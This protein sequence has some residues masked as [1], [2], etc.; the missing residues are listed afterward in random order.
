MSDR[1]ALS[2][3]MIVKNE[4]KF[5]PSCLHSVRDCVDEM[6]VVDTGST[7]RTIEIAE[8]FGAVVYH[9]PWEND[10]S[11]HR[12]QSIGYAKGDWIFWLDADET[13]E[14]G[15]GE[16]IRKAVAQDKIDSL[17]VTMVCY[18][19]NR[20][21]ESWNNTVKV[22]RN[23]VGI[24]FEGAVHNQVT[25][26]KVTGFCPTKIYHYG[27]DTDHKTVRRKFDRTSTLLKKAIRDD[28]H[29]FR[30]RH[31]LAVS[32]ASVGLYRKAVEEGVQAIGLYKE[33]GNRDPN[34]LWTHFVVASSY[35]NLGLMTQAKEISEAALRIQSDHLDSYFI[36]ASVCAAVEDRKGFETAYFT[37]IDLCRKYRENPELLA[38]LVMNKGNEKWRLDLEYASLLLKE[39][40]EQNAGK[41]FTSVIAENSDP[42]SA[43]LFAIHACR[44]AGHLTLAEQFLKTAEESGM[45]PR[46][47]AFEVAILGKL[48]GNRSD[49]LWK[50]ESML[51]PCPEDTPEFLAALGT[52][53]LRVHKF[54]EAES[55]F[56]ESFKRAYQTPSLFKKLALACKH[57]GK[58]AQAKEWNIKAL[59]MDEMDVRACVN[60]GHLC[61]EAKE[62]KDAMSWYNRALEIDGNQK[63]ALLR[64][65]LISLIEQDLPGCVSYCDRLAKTMEVPLDMEIGGIHDLS[66]V[67]RAIG[68]AFLKKGTPLLH[69]EAAKFADALAFGGRT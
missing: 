12:N 43:C 65:S 42:L 61:Y 69:Q 14:S 25:G 39:G 46:Q 48:S 58:S 67:Y 56:V 31:D 10:F 2:L 33:N 11:K 9:H 55:L 47:V 34:I 20:A 28:P 60:L 23:R 62:W 45:P 19:A 30:H 36:L 44:K 59:E 18:F 66:L 68:E 3:C 54:R 41:L 13:L 6:I 26:C 24:H 22:F 21:R 4:E 5:L 27:Y 8:S 37:Y 32:Y 16:V 17:L 1:P 29:N 53:A 49:Y 57:Q 50:M 52:E 51:R 35:F 40:S 38:G 64:L 15:G 63:D 7:D